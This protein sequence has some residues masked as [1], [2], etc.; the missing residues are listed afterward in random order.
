M[1]PSKNIGTFLNIF[2]VLFALLSCGYTSSRYSM[3]LNISVLTRSPPS[4]PVPSTHSGEC[5]NHSTGNRN[6]AQIPAT[7]G[8]YST[9]PRRKYDKRR[10]S[11]RNDFLLP[12][13]TT[14][15]P[16]TT[17]GGYNS[18]DPENPMLR[19]YIDQF[20]KQDMWNHVHVANEPVATAT[21]T[22]NNDEQAD[23]GPRL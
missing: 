16:P 3:C 2:N 21:T 8:H 22:G 9:R 4:S 13:T 18:N 23:P 7:I 11:A 6:S 17:H 10:A 14:H 1:D 19:R 12:R 15:G 20:H 5:A